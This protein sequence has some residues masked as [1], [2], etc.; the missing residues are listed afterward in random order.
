MTFGEQIRR[1]REI[2]NLSQEALAEAL[3]VSRQAVSKWENGTTMPQGANKAALVEILELDM[4][5]ETPAP[6]KR[7]VLRWLGWA[8]AGVLLA[9]LILIA[10][11]RNIIG[12]GGTDSVS[13]N[14]EPSTTPTETLSPEKAEEKPEIVSVRFYGDTQEEVLSISEH[15]LE[16]NT[17]AVEGILVQWTGDTPLENAKMFFLPYNAQNPSEA[18]LL[19]IKHAA[20]GETAILFSASY[21]HDENKKGSVYFELYF[22]DG[23]TVSSS[24]TYQIYYLAR[25]T[26]LVYVRDLVNG[27]LTYD[28]VEWVDEGSARAKELGIENTNNGFELYN[29]QTVWESSPVLENAGYW[30]LDLNSPSEPVVDSQDTFLANLE[31]Y[32]PCL[33]EIEI[34]NG[35]IFMITQQYLP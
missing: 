2:K 6:Q 20:K 18:E 32:Q 28:K 34:E 17:A 16:Y 4:K 7:D 1:A 21:L 26:Q 29:E 15:F 19:E 9:A 30:V 13:E 35:V 24:E 3:G 27:R 5:P 14:P 11:F 12:P 31:Y 10:V 8:V 22:Q 33:C 23:L 25:Q